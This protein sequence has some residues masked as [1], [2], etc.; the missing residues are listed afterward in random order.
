[1]VRRVLPI[2]PEPRAPCNSGMRPQRRVLMTIYTGP[3]FDMARQQFQV[4]KTVE[5]P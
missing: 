2:I 3:V 1:M 5:L 4:I